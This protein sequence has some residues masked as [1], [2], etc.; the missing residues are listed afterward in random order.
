MADVNT[1]AQLIS[2]FG[3]LKGKKINWGQID[4][5]KA[6]H[7]PFL[8]MGLM[9]YMIRVDKKVDTREQHFGNKEIERL[10]NIMPVEKGVDK[11]KLIDDLRNIFNNML[12]SEIPINK[13]LL[14]AN[15]HLSIETKR[16][17][18]RLMA[19]LMYAD[20]NL[21]KA[22]IEE[23]EFMA[24]SF[25]LAEDKELQAF[26]AKISNE[27]TKI[28][29][30]NLHP[31]LDIP[32]A[33][34]KLTGSLKDI[35]F[36]EMLFSFNTMV[37]AANNSQFDKIDNTGLPASNHAS[38]I[39]SENTILEAQESSF[40]KFMSSALSLQLED[41]LEMLKDKRSYL[42]FLQMGNK[43]KRFEQILEEK[44]EPAEIT[45]QKYKGLF[46]TVYSMTMANFDQM[47]IS[48]RLLESIGKDKLEADISAVKGS[49]DKMRLDKLNKRL[50]LLLEEKQKLDELY[51]L[52]ERSIQEMEEVSIE[53]S[54]LKGTSADE[55]Q[56]IDEAMKEMNLLKERIELF[57]K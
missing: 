52:N 31:V 53:L 2:K 43:L 47:F 45:Y 14:H 33:D 15:S 35:R 55:A 24:D 28:V 22:E 50:N 51:V 19:R 11:K 8:L 4:I 32:F 36:A 56:V 6:G 10:I 40:N 3:S 54:R 7:F 23:L 57:N 38:H 49:G 48:Q 5:K 46:K 9:A 21:D 30:T 25:G 20:S 41:K 37:L 42:Q 13:L 18:L 39:N 17:I 34:A 27:Q 44:L 16:N 1:I 29:K 12:S 26:R